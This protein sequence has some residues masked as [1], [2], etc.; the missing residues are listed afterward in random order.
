MNKTT[1]S[2]KKITDE[3]IINSLINSK[4]HQAKINSLLWE[5]Y[6]Q[7]KKVCVLEERLINIWCHQPM[8][9]KYFIITDLDGQIQRQEK[10]AMSTYEAVMHLHTLPRWVNTKNKYKKSYRLRQ[11][12][13]S[14][15]NRIKVT[16]GKD[17]IWHVPKAERSLD[18][19]WTAATWRSNPPHF[20]V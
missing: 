14:E 3:Y 1:G 4:I 5:C 2:I 7:G 8:I 16:K 6:C 20:F 18:S 9:W 17:N 12:T 15:R 11:S 10:C 19:L 13:V